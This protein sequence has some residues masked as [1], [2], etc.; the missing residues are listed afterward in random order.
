MYTY[1]TYTGLFDTLFEVVLMFPEKNTS[2]S[3][4]AHQ[5]SKKQIIG[6]KVNLVQ[7]PGEER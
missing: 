4:S 7:Y 2:A 1:T 5:V 6:Y 3:A